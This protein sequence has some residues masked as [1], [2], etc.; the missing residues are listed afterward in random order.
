[1]SRDNLNEA[2]RAKR[3]LKQSMLR[4]AFG[5]CP[6]CGKGPLFGK[7]LKVHDHCPDCGEAMHHHEADD[8]PAYFTIFIIGHL[9]VPA[10]IIIQKTWSP[11]VLLLL[12]VSLPLIIVLSLLL[13][14]RIK[15]ALIA[16]QWS[17]YMHGFGDAVKARA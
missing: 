14:P 4:G 10:A 15:G 5:R 6:A 9:I 17:Y 3:S 8:A 13:L 7:Y 2:G 11:D 16:I 1:M 12:G